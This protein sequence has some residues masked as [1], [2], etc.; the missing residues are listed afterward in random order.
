VLSLHEI[1]SEK[2]GSNASFIKGK[3]RLMWLI[4]L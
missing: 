1:K 4:T 3:T 2:K